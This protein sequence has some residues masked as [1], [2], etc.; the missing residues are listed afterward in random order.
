[1]TDRISLDHMPGHLIRRLQQQS[2]AVFQ[3][4]IKHA[5]FEVTSVQFAAL[6]T[7]SHKGEMDQAALARRIA[8][9]RATTG[10]VVKRLEARGLIRRVPD[11]T[12]RRAFRLSLTEEGNALLTALRP[13]VAQAQE[14]ILPGLTG[15]ERARFLSLA[16]KALEP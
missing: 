10:G 13:V 15:A 3:D 14:A 5:G 6:E 2:T 9:D 16:S 1:M 8:C 11:A 12:D 7:L 4:R